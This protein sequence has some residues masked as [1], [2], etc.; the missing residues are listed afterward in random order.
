MAFGRANEA[1]MHGAQRGEAW[2]E[3]K[4]TKTHRTAAINP[5]KAAQG[6]PSTQVGP[7]MAG[8]LVQ[9]ITEL[10]DRRRYIDLARN[11]RIAIHIVGGVATSEFTG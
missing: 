7:V 10:E 6:C 3:P 8:N 4:A 5:Q 11:V 9:S 2:K 1:T